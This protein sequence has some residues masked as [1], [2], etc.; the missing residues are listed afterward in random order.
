M[1]GLTFRLAVIAAV[2]IAAGTPAAG[3]SVGLDA[4]P[5][6]VQQVDPIDPEAVRLPGKA[7]HSMPVRAVFDQWLGDDLT[8]RA[9]ALRELSDRGTSIVP[10]LGE[11]L[12]GPDLLRRCGAAHLAADIGP[13]ARRMT[14]ALVAL[15]RE[16]AAFD[17][18]PGWC[19]SAGGALA[20][21]DPA[22]FTTELDRAV[23]SR[24][25]PLCRALAPAARHQPAPTPVLLDALR[26]EACSEKAAHALRLS[27]PAR[28]DALPGLIAAMNIP[29][30]FAR[31]RVI[32][33]VGQTVAGATGTERSAGIAAAMPA[34]VA[35]L[36][37]PERTVRLAAADALGGLGTDAGP[38]VPSLAR[39]LEDPDRLV[40]SR[41]LFA[42]TRLGT[43]GRP[44]GAALLK[45]VGAPLPPEDD[46]R[47][48]LE[49]EVMKKQLEAAIEA[50]GAGKDDAELSA[51]DEIRAE[52]VVHTLAS[53]PTRDRRHGQPVAVSLTN[54]FVATHEFMPPGLVAALRRRGQA[55]AP[56]GTLFEFGP[57]QWAT[58]DA[59]IVKAAIG[60]PMEASGA[61]YRLARRG[62]VWTVLWQEDRWIN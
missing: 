34:L 10:F 23:R 42:L 26:L 50:T 8:L 52:V 48:P 21:V 15:V 24:N 27:E 61:T 51:E 56:D 28:P 53:L 30:P 9:E 13:A 4:E 55:T 45:L 1:A 32:G 41:V 17:E 12:G 58:P 46:L 47:H 14:P 60:S 11:E 31:E 33:V 62:G 36:R 5:R 38:A 3:A 54:E 39:A 2:T 7:I 40:R 16:T 59:A 22:A 25:V 57:V 20:S 37:D 43:T 18:P 35:A 49:D 29:S 6:R 19:A 44:A